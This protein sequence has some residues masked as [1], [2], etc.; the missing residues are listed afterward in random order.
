MP[1]APLAEQ[2]PQKEG[3]LWEGRLRGF[4]HLPT[5]PHPKGRE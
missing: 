2:T 5:F 1:T 3:Q 4:P